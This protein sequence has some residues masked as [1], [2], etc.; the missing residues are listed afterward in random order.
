MDIGE[1]LE[2]S[3]PAQFRTWLRKNHG[4]KSEIWLIQYK[5]ASGKPTLSLQQAQD[6]AMCFGWVDSFMKSIDLERYATRFSPR[7]PKSNWTQGNR[8]RALQLAAEGRMTSAGKAALPADMRVLAGLPQ[9]E[10]S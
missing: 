1:T 6:E 8:Q 7:R 10:E 3:T 5:K 2:A 4:K 9:Q